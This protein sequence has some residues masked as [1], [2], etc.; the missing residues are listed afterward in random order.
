MQTVK[1]RI[2]S[3]V[4]NW[5]AFQNET[6]TS[7]H[8]FL[9][10]TQIIHQLWTVSRR[11]KWDLSGHAIKHD[12]PMKDRAC[13][14]PAIFPVLTVRRFIRFTSHRNSNIHIS[15]SHSPLSCFSSHLEW[16]MFGTLEWAMSWAL[17]QSLLREGSLCT[18]SSTHIAVQQS[19]A[20]AVSMAVAHFPQSSD[21]RSVAH[22]ERCPAG[23]AALKGA[24]LIKPGCSA[25]ECSVHALGYGS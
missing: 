24:A 21:R 20:S 8:A 22:T 2:R 12:D 16:P 19:T 14:F 4:L 25:H 11:G 15:S 1:T 9:S 3:R 10:H 13:D 5:T 6:L 17:S 23:E 18:F 7:L